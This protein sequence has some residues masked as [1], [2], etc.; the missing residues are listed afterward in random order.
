VR[1]AEH[2]AAEHEA[3]LRRVPHSPL[4]CRRTKLPTQWQRCCFAPAAVWARTVDRVEPLVECPAIGRCPAKGRCYRYMRPRCRDSPDLRA[5]R[6]VGAICQPEFAHC[7]PSARQPSLKGT[8]VRSRGAGEGADPRFPVPVPTAAEGNRG[9]RR[10][11]LRPGSPTASG[12]AGPAGL[13]SRPER[14]LPSRP[15]EARVGMRRRGRDI[16]PGPH[17]P[18]GY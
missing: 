12:S 1:E 5:R 17:G 9:S 11:R 10:G 8:E 13:V 6:Q 14:T 2:E 18:S 15:M 3:R 16:G 4:T 7:D